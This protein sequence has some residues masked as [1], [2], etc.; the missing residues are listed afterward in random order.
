MREYFIIINDDRR[1]PFPAEQLASQGLNSRING[2]VRR[3]A[4][5]AAG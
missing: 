2:L 4:R 3:H 5:L 1:G